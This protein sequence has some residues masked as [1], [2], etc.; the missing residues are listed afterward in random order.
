MSIGTPQKNPAYFRHS[1]QTHSRMVHSGKGMRLR[2]SW[3]VQQAKLWLLKHFVLSLMVP[4]WLLARLLP[5]LFRLIGCAFQG[6]LVIWSLPMHNPSSFTFYLP[7][8]Q[9]TKQIQA[10]WE[11][12]GG[13]GLE[14][15]KANNTWIFISGFCFYQGKSHYLSWK[16]N[17]A[18]F[19]FS[20]RWESTRTS[21]NQCDILW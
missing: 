7:Q 10:V 16:S 6:A 21:E 4:E 1:V 5:D 13:S 15:G 12:L 17:N 2:K 18:P 20:K 19:R 9:K 14:L 8:S 11:R 3:V